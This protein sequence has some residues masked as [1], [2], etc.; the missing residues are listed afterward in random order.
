MYYSKGLKYDL[1]GKWNDLSF[2]AGF[3]RQDPKRVGFFDVNE[4]PENGGVESIKEKMH[5]MLKGLR[6]WC[7]TASFSSE[8]PLN[9]L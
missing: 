1:K 7:G 9:S 8:Q 4:I 6:F 3:C 2:E 5:L